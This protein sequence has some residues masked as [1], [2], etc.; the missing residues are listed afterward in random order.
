MEEPK[1]VKASE[2][3][4]D[5]SGTPSMTDSKGHPIDLQDPSQFAPKYPAKFASALTADENVWIDAEDL[6]L[7]GVPPERSPTVQ[8]FAFPRS[9][10]PSTVPEPPQLA[11]PR[12]LVRLMALLVM[13]SVVAGAFFVMWGR[14]KPP[15]GGDEAD[16]SSL[17]TRFSALVAGDSRHPIESTPHLVVTR[18]PGDLHLDEAT[19]LGVAVDGAASGA[20]VVIGGVPAG[21]VF[22]AGRSIG[23]AAWSLPAW[24]IETATL[25]PPRG[26][27]GVMAVAITLMQ[28]NGNLTDRK[29]VHLQWV[30]ETPA[31]QVPE[32]AI[33]RRLDPSE[34]NALI[35]RANA[36]VATG[37]LSGARLLYRRAAEAGN[38]RAALTLAE[39]YD[40]DV[41]ETLGESGL[42]PNVGMARAWYKK[43]KELGSADAPARLERLQR[44]T[45]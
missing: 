2:S 10:D 33:S 14:D 28:A 32:P 41:L 25:T 31:L 42:A 37:D 29:V 18:A 20:Q 13:A 27:V 35:A 6:L 3:F 39:T 38:A 45:E 44:R 17:V 12:R 43:A 22:S 4:R 11:R 26:F 24:Q 21:S 40:P 34:L 5:T 16:T 30:P 19:T 7:G 15:R 23:T 36:L 9:L 8:N 1:S